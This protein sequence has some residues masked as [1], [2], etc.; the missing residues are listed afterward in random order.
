MILSFHDFV[1]SSGRER[2]AI[3]AVELGSCQFLC[4]RLGWDVVFKL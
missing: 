4:F 2:W 1:H 3:H